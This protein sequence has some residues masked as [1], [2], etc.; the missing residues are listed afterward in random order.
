MTTVETIVRDRHVS[1]TPRPVSAGVSAEGS[2]WGAQAVDD[3]LVRISAYIVEPGADTERT[4]HTAIMS[5]R[6]NSVLQRR[7]RQKGRLCG[8]AAAG[9]PPPSPFSDG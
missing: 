4:Q 1:V 9:I 7:R 6:R 2:A 3:D 8:G 5:A